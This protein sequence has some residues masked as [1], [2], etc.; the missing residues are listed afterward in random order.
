MY[1][2]VAQRQKQIGNIGSWQ[3]C[4]IVLILL[5][6]GV[7]TAKKECGMWPKMVMTSIKSKSS[8]ITFGCC[9]NRTPSY[10][11]GRII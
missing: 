4:K 1:S 3:N 5:T 7:K 8:C 9:S 6:T 11:N 10:D 2:L